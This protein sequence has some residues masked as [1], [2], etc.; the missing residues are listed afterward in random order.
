MTDAQVFLSP[1]RKSSHS[2]GGN[3]CVE[4]AFTAAGATVRDSK[5]VDGGMLSFSSRGWRGLLDATRSGS[6]DHS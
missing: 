5:D 3:D 2:G 4:I 1:W 6:L